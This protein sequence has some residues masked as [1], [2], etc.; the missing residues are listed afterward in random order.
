MDYSD[1][2]ILPTGQPLPLEAWMYESGGGTCFMLF[3]QFND[4]DQNWEIVPQEAYTS[5]PA[6]TTT[7]VPST[8]T[9][10]TST[11]TT[12]TTST[13]PSPQTTRAPS[14]VLTTTTATT[15]PTTT[16]T[17]TTSTTT[18]TVLPET[19]TTIGISTTTPSNLET[20]TSVETVTETTTSTVVPDTTTTVPE[21]TTT[22]PEP[23]EVQTISPKVTQLLS[24]AGALTTEEV[25]T[26]VDA[27]ISEGL[28][29]SEAVMLAQDPDIIAQVTE[30]Q[31]QEIFATVDEGGL[32]D[33]QGLA[34]VEAV[35]NAPVEI[36][37]VFEAEVNVFGGHTDTYVP[38]GSVVTVRQRR[39]MIV[40]GLISMSAV[41]MPSPRSNRE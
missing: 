20:T 1:R 35:Q 17:S 40:A 12:T 3:W 33:E 4:D 19:T 27:V 2:V 25:Q 13:A 32:T 9:S 7:S 8:T 38:V 23:V 30:E 31:A 21:T 26:A 15:S 11:S 18:V 36:R 6:E 37:K 16:I 24:K 39:V 14:P 5:T 29:K 28:N 22:V 41:P 10:T 34:I